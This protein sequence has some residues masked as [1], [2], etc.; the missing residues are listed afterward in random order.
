M[1]RGSHPVAELNRAVAV[2]EVEGPRAG[3]DLLEGLAGDLGTFSAWHVARAELWRR[4]DR[5]DD[6]RAAYERAIALTENV[7]EPDH[8]RG[9]PSSLPR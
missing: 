2:A 7:P 5:T 8:P 3:L 9:R 6:A 1:A 4:L